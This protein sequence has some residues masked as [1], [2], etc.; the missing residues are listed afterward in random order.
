MT[1]S[2]THDHSAHGADD[3][4]VNPHIAS[5]RRHASVLGALLVFTLLTVGAYTVNLGEWNLAVAII[6]STIKSALVVWFFMELKD[7]TAFNR[8]IFIGAL[9]FVGLFMAYTMNDTR[10]RNRID[11]FNGARVDPRSGELANGT[12]RGIVDQGGELGP[13]PV[14]AAEP[15]ATPAAE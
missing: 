11:A 7:D 5:A 10:H 15:E 6:I 12:A 2:S 9:I 1:D 13:L 8:L 14:I 3:F 4:H